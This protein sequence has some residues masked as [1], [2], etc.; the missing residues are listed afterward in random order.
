MFYQE[1]TYGTLT[2]ECSQIEYELGSLLCERYSEVREEFEQILR[3]A[4]RASSMVENVNGRIRTYMGRV[5]W[6]L[7][8]PVYSTDLFF[9][10]HP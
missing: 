5:D 6:P 1:R 4:K 7:T 8:E 3:S 10:L 2:W 9:V